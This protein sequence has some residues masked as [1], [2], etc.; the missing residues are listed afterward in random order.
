MIRVLKFDEQVVPNSRVARSITTST[1]P[2]KSSRPATYD[3]PSGRF[4]SGTRGTTWLTQ[5]A[6]I[7]N[8]V[9]PI[10]QVRRSM[11]HRPCDR[12]SGGRGSCRTVR[13]SEGGT[14]RRR[15]IKKSI[16]RSLCPAFSLSLRPFSDAR[17]GRILALPCIRH[18]IRF[19][20]TSSSLKP[21]NVIAE[22]ADRLAQLLGCFM[23]FA[24]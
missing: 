14:E 17:L 13:G 1:V 7:T 9:E 2:R 6:S 4:R 8:R 3:S 19:F 22:S 15:D 5:R 20:G 10:Q 18:G 21:R 16:W 24:Y 11:T 23:E 12:A